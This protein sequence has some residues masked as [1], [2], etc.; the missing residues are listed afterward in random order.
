VSDTAHVEQKS[1]RV[2]APA[3]IHPIIAAR[4]LIISTARG[5]FNQGRADA[6]RHVRGCH[7]Q[8]NTRDANE[9]ALDD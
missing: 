9:L 6:A 7:L 1:E 8:K 5:S 4:P 2:Y 3:S